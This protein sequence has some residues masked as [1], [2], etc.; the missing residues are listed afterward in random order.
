MK[1]SRWNASSQGFKCIRLRPPTKELEFHFK[2]TACRMQGNNDRSKKVLFNSHKSGEIHQQFLTPLKFFHSFWRETSILKPIKYSET[3]LALRIEAIST[4]A[5][6][7]FTPSEDFLDL[8]PCIV[9][10]QTT[11]TLYVYNAS[12]FLPV[13]FSFA[14][15]AHYRITPSEGLIAPRQQSAVEVMFSPKQ[16]GSS[17]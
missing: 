8:G 17:E 6:V 15:L 1:C 14:P 4:A 3:D 2:C 12:V 7:R 10:S 16:A 5:D 13:V 11:T 9:G